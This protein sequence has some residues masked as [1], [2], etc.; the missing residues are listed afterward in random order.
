MCECP[1]SHVWHRHEAAMQKGNPPFKGGTFRLYWSLLLAWLLFVTKTHVFKWLTV[2]SHKSQWK[3][4]TV[5][6]HIVFTSVCKL[7]FTTVNASHRFWINCGIVSLCFSWCTGKK[8][9]YTDTDV[10]TPLAHFLYFCEWHTSVSLLCF[11]NIWILCCVDM[12]I[13]NWSWAKLEM[14]SSHSFHF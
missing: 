9:V 1:Q 7:W 11:T 14:I 4:K 3:P 5:M 13:L 12:I 8:C 6:I 2:Q 10:Y